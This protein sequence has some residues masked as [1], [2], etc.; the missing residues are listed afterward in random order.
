[1]QK[2]ILAS[3]SPRRRQI[4]LGMGLEFEVLTSDYEETLEDACFSYEKIE[5]LAC[6]K[7]KAVLDKL[8]SQSLDCKVIIIGADT[9]VVLDNKIL[10]KPQDKQDAFKMLKVLSG[11]KHFVVTSVCAIDGKTKQEKVL[12]TTSYVEF[13]E[14][15]D[16]QINHYIETFKP[17][18]K[19]GAYGIQELPEGF[20]KS[21]EG[22]FENII[23]LCPSA[24]REIL[25]LK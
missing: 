2:I 15:S 13:E 8:C 19:A 4:L 5:E 3:S 6:N 11:K 23:G 10:G 1:M 22:S 20:V 16:N 7:A 24:V 25:N 14:L 21:V 17:F 18:D 12:S 9:V